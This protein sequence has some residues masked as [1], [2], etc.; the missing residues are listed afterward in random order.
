MVQLR[1][2]DVHRVFVLLEVIH[3]KSY[4]PVGCWRLTS[5]GKGQRKRS[6]VG[7]GF[8]NWVAGMIYC[9]HSCPHTFDVCFFA[10][11]QQADFTYCSADCKKHQ[12]ITGEH[13]CQVSMRFSCRSNRANVCDMWCVTTRCGV[14]FDP[15]PIHSPL[16]H[17]ASVVLP[18]NGQGIFIC[19]MVT[20]RPAF[21]IFGVRCPKQQR[22]TRGW[23][24]VSDF[25]FPK[26]C[27]VGSNELIA[28]IS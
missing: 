13:L 27:S 8:G 10:F 3:W 9:A 15:G 4:I 1:I 7:F 18:C 23:V 5:R 24:L 12:G 6:S 14:N 19:L 17:I 21:W 25:V 26:H 2:L 11:P 16:A 20:C 28:L 22:E